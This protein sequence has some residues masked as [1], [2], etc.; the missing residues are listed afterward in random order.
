MSA[1][2]RI[3][4]AIAGFGIIAGVSVLGVTL[5]IG[6][7]IALFAAITAFQAVIVYLV[8]NLVAPM[9]AFVPVEY[10]TLGFLQVWGAVAVIRIIGRVL[11]A[12]IKKDD[13][14]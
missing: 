4:S 7:A 12:T 2:S 6:I 5:A 3:A 8:W 9:F 10:Q 1:A 13:R 14:K 11:F